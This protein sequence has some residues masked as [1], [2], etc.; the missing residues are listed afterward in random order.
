MNFECPLVTRSNL[1]MSLPASKRKLFNILSASRCDQMCG[2][3]QVPVSV[4]REGSD[5]SN[6]ALK[7]G[8]SLVTK[9]GDALW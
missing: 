2:G 1:F 9:V 5:H 3:S 7:F 8:G 4:D 6:A